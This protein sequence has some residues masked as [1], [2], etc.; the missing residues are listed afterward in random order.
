MYQKELKICKE[1]IFEAS[2][3]ILKIYNKSF[4]VYEK[5]DNSPVTKADLVAN[6]IIVEKL[7]NNFDYNIISE[8]SQNQISNSNKSF[9]IDPIDGTKEFIKKNGEFSI[10][11]AILNKNELE[12]GIIYAPVLDELYYAI[13][14]KG[15]YFEKNN[16]VKKINVSNNKKKVNLLISQSHQR[17]KSLRLIEKNKNKINK[18]DRLG[19]SLKGCKIAK[20]DSDAYYRFGPTSIWDTAAMEVIVTQAGGKLLTMDNKKIDYT[21][22]NPINPSF[23]IINDL[24]NKF[25]L[26]NI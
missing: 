17:K 24:E 7:T 15:A 2:K 10:N 20:G 9:I 23:F 22:D 4:K 5:E 1:A 14:G 26:N 21:K 3:K 13:K 12:F 25:D 8:E 16:K 19:S 11:I 18:I 6:K